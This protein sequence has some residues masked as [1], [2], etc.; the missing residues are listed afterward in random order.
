MAIL[1]FGLIIFSTE[2]RKSSSAFS[3]SFTAI[4]NAWKLFVAGWMNFG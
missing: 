3:S 2:S 4:R 1:P